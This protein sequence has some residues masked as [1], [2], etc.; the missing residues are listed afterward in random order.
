[1]ERNYPEEIV[2]E[3]I[4]RAETKDRQTL[5]FKQRNLKSKGDKKVTVIFTN[6]QAN[7]PIHQWIREGKIYLKSTKARA[8]A[9]NMQIVYKQHKKILKS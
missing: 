3:Q 6:N 1:M 4:Q 7:H 9:D 8:L 2:D 5:K